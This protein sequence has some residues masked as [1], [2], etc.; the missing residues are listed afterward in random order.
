MTEGGPGYI[1]RLAFMSFNTVDGGKVH[2]FDLT[3]GAA[4]L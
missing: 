2:V 4:F 3:T 1:H